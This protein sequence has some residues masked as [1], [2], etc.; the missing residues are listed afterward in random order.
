MAANCLVRGGLCHQW[1]GWA[2]R[3]RTCCRTAIGRGPSVLR[4][5]SLCFGQVRTCS[6]WGGPVQTPSPA[7]PGRDKQ[8]GADWPLH[9]VLTEEPVTPGRTNKSRSN[10]LTLEVTD[11]A[12]SHRKRTTPKLSKTHREREPGLWVCSRTWIRGAPG[13]TVAV[14]GQGAHDPTPLRAGGPGKELDSPP[15]PRATWPQTN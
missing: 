8:G 5:Q 7:P 2:G 11:T 4:A 13:G 6:L 14:T 15:S 12:L 9:S 3:G 10:S 1:E